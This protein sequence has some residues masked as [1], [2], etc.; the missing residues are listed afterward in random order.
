MELNTESVLVLGGEKLLL[1]AKRMRLRSES[2]ETVSPTSARTWLK[3]IWQGHRSRASSNNNTLDGRHSPMKE[4]PREG[5][6]QLPPQI[7]AHFTIITV[8]NICF[9]P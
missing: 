4:E 1:F 5:R 6:E 9:E 8:T 3:K 2:A 7:S